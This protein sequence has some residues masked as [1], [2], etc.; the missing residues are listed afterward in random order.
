M[1]S[2]KVVCIR[3]DKGFDD[4]TVGKSYILLDSGDNEMVYSST[5]IY[6]GVINDNGVLNYYYHRKFIKLEEYRKLKLER[7][8]SI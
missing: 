8:N 4:L 6:Y 2:S 7:L 1:R 5:G 3:I